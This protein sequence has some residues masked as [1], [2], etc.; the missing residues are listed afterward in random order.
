M[1]SEDQ[2]IRVHRHDLLGGFVHSTGSA[3]FCMDA[4]AFRYAVYGHPEHGDTSRPVRYSP[5]RR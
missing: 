2:Q 3:S 1:V 4:F 5:S